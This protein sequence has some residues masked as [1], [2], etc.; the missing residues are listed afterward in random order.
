VRS[1]AVLVTLALASPAGAGTVRGKVQ[2]LEKSSRKTADL[3]DVVV[4]V[5]GVRVKAE[6]GRATMGMKGKAF[7]PHVLAVGVGT[8]VDFPNDDPIFHNV[9]S[10]TRD[11]DF[12]LDL[13]KRPK[14]G[15]WKFK[16]PGIVRVYCNIHPQ[17]SAVVVVRD[18]PFFTKAGPDGSFEIADVPAGRYP[19]RAWHERAAQGATTEVTV[20]AS[21][22]AE[23]KLVL[24]AASYKRVQHKKKDGKDYGGDEKY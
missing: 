21:G 23:A 1:V 9:F 10:V 15:Q 12:D 20:P 11:N 4:W 3:A 24:D 2:L 17:M 16:N 8:T 6:P 14:S 19:L 13:Y 7:T 22:Q 5:E 18:N